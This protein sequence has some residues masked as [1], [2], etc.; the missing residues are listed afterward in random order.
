MGTQ[1]QDE[2]EGLHELRDIHAEEVS[3]VDR[4]ANKR[5]FLV[6]KCEGPDG[7]GT[8]G[9][10]LRAKDDGTFEV[11]KTEEQQ[12]ESQAEKG[13]QAP[14]APGGRP[15]MDEEEEEEDGGAGGAPPPPAR[16]EASE[17]EPLEKGGAK[18]SKD[19]Y[20]RLKQAVELLNSI[21]SEVS[22]MEPGV[23]AGE[24]QEEETLERKETEK[25]DTTAEESLAKLTD[26]VVAISKFV[27]KLAASRG[28]GNAQ[29][30]EKASKQEA[31]EISW[32]RD[33]TRPITRETV[34]KERGF[35]D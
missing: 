1:Q 24:S 5:R 2:K 18:M 23:K 28:S 32:P 8:M 3:I 21:F 12:E 33:M 9:A 4:A 17:E 16:K 35:W 6:V 34:G 11:V 14:P 27:E 10:E 25:S 29:G 13:K 30:V 7:R 26:Q 19:R 20:N 31:Q 15:Q 22:P